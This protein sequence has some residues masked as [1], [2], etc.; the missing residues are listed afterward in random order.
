M[1]R[2]LSIVVLCI[3]SCVALN[4]AFNG[5]DSSQPAAVATEKPVAVATNDDSAPVSQPRRPVQP[6]PVYARKP[7]YDFGRVSAGKRIR[8]SFELINDSDS[9]V[10]LGRPI[11]ECGCTTIDVEGMVISPHGHADIPITM[12]TAGMSG[13]QKKMVSLRVNGS[14]EKLRLW[15]YGDVIKASGVTPNNIAFGSLEASEVATKS[16]RISFQSPTV[17]KFSVTS[18]SEFVSARIVNATKM[19]F[20]VEVSTVPPLPRSGINTAIDIESH[21][22]EQAFR[23]PITGHVAEG[24]EA[25]PRMLT[26]NVERGQS[27]SESRVVVRQNS[28]KGNG[29]VTV[30]SPRLY[31]SFSVT[32]M[33]SK[34]SYLVRLFDGVTLDGSGKYTVSITAAEST[35]QVPVNVVVTD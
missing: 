14:T 22:G 35:I 6:L 5:S 21:D 18:P 23:V 3:A 20:M 19:Q 16:V 13:A 10:T 34:S 26:L 7:T 1:L 25:I 32:P 12:N 29:A 24:L 17:G 11:A 27:L 28:S 30:L 2:T 33:R 4:L 31:D 15:I 9:P 8:S